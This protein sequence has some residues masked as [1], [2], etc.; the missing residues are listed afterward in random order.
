M[1]GGQ[2]SDGRQIGVGC[3]SDRCQMPTEGLLLGGRSLAS[4]PPAVPMEVAK[5]P[6]LPLTS[7]VFD[8]GG[9]FNLAFAGDDGARLVEGF[10][11]EVCA[12][13]VAGWVFCGLF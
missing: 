4:S 13:L 8:T 5:P 9:A 6:C 3:M 2:V 12:R 1:G 10:V 11:G 7:L